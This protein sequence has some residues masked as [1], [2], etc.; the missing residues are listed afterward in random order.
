MTT[1][2]VTGECRISFPSLFEKTPTQK[3]GD[4]LKYQATCVIPNGADMS[5]YRKAM[6]AAL[7]KKGWTYATLNADLPIKPVDPAKFPGCEGGYTFRTR[8]D[9]KPAVV[10][11]SV[12][13]ILDPAKI[14]GGCVVKFSLNCYAYDVNGNKGLSF[15]LEAVQ[16]IR[17]G[18]R[19]GGGVGYD[20]VGK[21]FQPV[22]RAPGAP[23]GETAPVTST[24]A[25]VAGVAGAPA[26]DPTAALFGNPAAPAANPTSGPGF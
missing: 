13:Q 3:N 25:A 23:A 6:D 16:F 4:K 20:N 24:P 26:A 8:S 21:V 10:D 7:A 1:S 12:N 9:T 22:E 17:D 2:V 19:F 11:E 14:Y 15:G 5:I 18:E